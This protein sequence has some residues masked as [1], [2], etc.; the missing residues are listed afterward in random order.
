M[1]ELPD[2]RPK[3]DWSA[4]RAEVGIT[5]SRGNSV[6]QPAM[7]VLMR[8]S[9]RIRSSRPQA[10]L[11]RCST[12]KWEEVGVVALQQKNETTATFTMKTKRILTVKNG[13]VGKRDTL[14]VKIYQC[15]KVPTSFSSLCILSL[16]L[17][18]I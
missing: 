15:R 14:K 10:S 13:I 3:T 17:H 7:A 9:F 5:T 8:E 11:R 6:L 2:L 16:I 1:H 18:W 4:Y 12:V